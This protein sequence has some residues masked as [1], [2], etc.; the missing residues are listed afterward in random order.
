MTRRF[1]NIAKTTASDLVL[2]TTRRKNG[3]AIVASNNA[4]DV[5]AM[6]AWS[7]NGN[8]EYMLHTELL[9][10]CSTGPCI[11]FLLSAL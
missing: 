3:S 2:R 1:P 5:K 8:E 11:M 6:L 4:H 9:S 7:A 10:G